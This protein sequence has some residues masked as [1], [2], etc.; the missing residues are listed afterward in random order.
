MIE[1]DLD[2]KKKLVSEFEIG[3][4]ERLKSVTLECCEH[5]DF[6]VY[7]TYSFFQYQ[8]DNLCVFDRLKALCFHQN[9]TLLA[10]QNVSS[11]LLAQ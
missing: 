10:Q 8:Y 11:Q 7:S 4:K 3:Q 9:P 6:K 5:R 1:N 2:K